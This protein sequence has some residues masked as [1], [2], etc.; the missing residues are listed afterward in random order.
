MQGRQTV[1][2]VQG[3]NNDENMIPKLYKYLIAVLV[4]STIILVVQTLS[5]TYLGSKESTF[6]FLFSGGAPSDIGPLDCLRLIWGGHYFGDFQSEFCRMRQV[7]PYPIDRPSSYLPGFYVVSGFIGMF[8]SSVTAFFMFVLLALA[9]G[10]YVVRT[11]FERKDLVKISPLVL[12]TFYPF[13][14]AIDRGN[15][16]WIFGP[17]LVLFGTTRTA[18]SERYWILAVAISLKFPLAVFGLL[19]FAD[20]SWKSKFKE[21]S[22]F[23]GVFIFLNFLFPVLQ[24][25]GAQKWPKTVLQMQ[26]LIPGGSDIGVKSFN[27]NL[28]GRSD[29]YTF[30]TSFQRFSFLSEFQLNVFKSV[31]AGIVFLVIFKSIKKLP[32][33]GNRAWGLVE[34]SI[35]SGCLSVLLSPFSFTYGLMALLVPIVLLLSPHGD[36][37]RFRNTYLMLLAVSS[38]PNAIPLRAMCELLF[39]PIEGSLNADFPDLGNFLIPISLIIML[40]LV[41]YSAVLSYLSTRETQ[42]NPVVV[43]VDLPQ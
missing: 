22:K 7:T 33:I 9:F 23:A 17:L 1:F 37:V 16:G 12:L 40:L 32:K 39:H 34:L 41:A 25:P 30:L 26:G 31:L 38:V 28:R 42:H 5:N 36:A 4:L 13:W 19:L 11:Q 10:V 8:P 18:R 43:S 35:V 27:F 2:E 3:A 6:P 15:Y 14:F 29:K 24:W 21:V 20:G